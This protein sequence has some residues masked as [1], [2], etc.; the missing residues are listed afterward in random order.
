MKNL[1]KTKL[2]IRQTKATF[3]NLVLIDVIKLI[4]SLTPEVTFI[5]STIHS[6]TFQFFEKNLQDI[7]DYNTNEENSTLTCCCQKGQ[8]E[9]IIFESQQATTEDK[10]PQTL[11][12][13]ENVLAQIP[14][15]IDM[16]VTL[17]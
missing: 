10:N 16:S 7:V 2:N 17:S 4:D 1:K 11:P 15:L 14:H 6:E 12:I 9:D 8:N 13:R 5:A 3:K